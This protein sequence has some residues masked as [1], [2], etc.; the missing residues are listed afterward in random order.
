MSIQ[1]VAF[2]LDTHVPEVAAKMLLV[3]LANAHNQETGLCC[4]SVNR[5]AEESSMS[6][7]SVQRWLKWLA[8]TGLIEIVEKA[9]SNGRQQANEYRIAGFVRG[10]KL[11]PSPK[12][13]GVTADT[14]EGDTPDT[15]VGA[16]A[17]APLKE[18]EEYRKNERERASECV[19]FDEIWEVFPRR[20]LTNRKDALA[21]FDDL[22]DAEKTRLLI[23]AKRFAQWH[24]EDC[25]VRNATP[26]SQLEFRTG[27]GKWIRSGAWAA[28]LNVSLRS[29]PVPPTAEGLVVL[30]P[31]HPDV[32]AV[33]KLRGKPV[34]LS[35]KTGNA[36]LRIEEIEQA[37][38][39]SPGL[40][41]P[42]LQ[43]RID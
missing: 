8:E 22:S 13:R 40:Q 10:A 28:A 4:P 30:P 31:N 39:R 12:G 1:A 32:K 9:D 17:D 43:P 29:D 5:L 2:V 27:L 6:R 7:R 16:T 36:T 35:S 34:V 20:K 42:D 21:A 11:T 24:V 41:S 15:L 14:G 26:E 18:P 38:A 25:E 23:A 33:E 3:C 19:S 37:R